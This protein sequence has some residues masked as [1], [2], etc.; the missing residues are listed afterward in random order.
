[1][2]QLNG[3]NY[4]SLAEVE[5][6]GGTIATGDWVGTWGT[7]PAAPLSNSQAGYPNHTVRN[8]VHTSVSGTSAR[9]RLSNRFGA[10]PLVI[11][12]ASVGLRA[13]A[14]T[15]D[16][17]G[18]RELTFS[19]RTSVTI[20]AGGDV[21]SD[22]VAFTVPAD[23]DLLVSLFTPQ[24]SGPVTYHP[25]AQQMSYLTSAGDRTMDTSGAAYQQQIGSFFYVKEIDVLG[26]PAKGSLVA[27]GDSI[28]DGGYSTTGANHRWPDYLADR[29]KQLPAESRYGVLNSG[30]SAN[31]LLLD[32]NDLAYGRS[33][34]ARLDDDAIDRTAVKTVILLEG[35]NDLHQD[36]READP[37]K[38]IA[39][40][41]ELVERLHAKGIRVFAG[42][43]T[44]IKGWSSFTEGLEATRTAINQFIRTGGLFDGYFDFDKALGDPQDPLRLRPE[45]DAGDHVHP[46]DAGNE[47]IAATIDLTRI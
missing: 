13:G 42:T 18:L 46:S 32:G 44:P 28:T 40:Y 30:I 15:A 3:T 9:V 31:R 20:P 47:A 37:Q 11:G 43:L 35:L 25:A 10:N 45:Y 14:D 16:A 21:Q 41:R 4:L 24:S 23:A 39:G 26:A 8:V 29:M 27:F 33:A 12:K 19:G 2:V 22:S 17:T 36:P 7:A 1:M 6:F 5:V 38:F 34:L